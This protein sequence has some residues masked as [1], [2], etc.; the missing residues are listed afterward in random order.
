MRNWLYRSSI[1]PRDCEEQ[2]T[3]EERQKEVKE[4]GK[5]SEKKDPCER[6][7]GGGERE[8]GRKKKGGREKERE[9]RGKRKREGGE[10]EKEARGR[11]QDK[12]LIYL[13]HFT[14]M[15][16]L[17]GHKYH[18]ISFSFL[19]AS[20]ENVQFQKTAS[21][22]VTLCITSHCQ[23]TLLLRLSFQPRPAWAEQ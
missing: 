21:T 8:G 13:K 12:I 22:T 6:E 10:R 1:R 9:G 11:G 2:V 14:S 5:I 7:R 3:I 16:R 4:R 20:G 19:W 15:Y 18:C 23:L 17:V